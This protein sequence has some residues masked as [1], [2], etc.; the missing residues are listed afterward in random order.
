VI[1]ENSNQWAE[2]EGNG[3][4]RRRKRVVNSRLKFNPGTV[5]NPRTRACV[6]YVAGTKISGSSSGSIYDY[7]QAKNLSIS[8]QVDGQYVNVYDYERKCYVSGMLPN[9]FD[10][11]SGAPVS[12]EV[13]GQNF[14]GYDYSTKHH[15]S[16][17]VSGNSVS[18]YDH[19]ESKYFRYTV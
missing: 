11:G 17:S 8:G 18:L 12:V 7:A 4:D 2:A 19:G 15:F 13:S 9:L 1:S 5:M 16:G 10:Y 3:L 6:A 14:S